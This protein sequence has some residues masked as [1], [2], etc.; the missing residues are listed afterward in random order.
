M[1]CSGGAHHQPSGASEPETCLPSSGVH[2][3]ERRVRWPHLQFHE[4]P[5]FGSQAV[6]FPQWSRRGQLPAFAP[7]PVSRFHLQADLRARCE[8][9]IRLTPHLPRGAELTRRFKLFE[10]RKLTTRR[11]LMTASTCV[12]GFRPSRIPFRCKINRPKLRI[13]TTSPSARRSA[14]SSNTRSTSVEA[15]C[16]ETPSCSNISRA[17]PA[18]VN[19]PLRMRTP[20]EP[21][22]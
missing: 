16:W 19:V 5:C 7:D 2:A 14:I 18:R 9:R 17:R 8:G 11:G 3:A 12:F 21:D 13:L 1:G 22:V 4:A 10:E 6:R 15:S 20:V